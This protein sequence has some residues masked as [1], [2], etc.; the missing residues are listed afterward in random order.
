MNENLK[1]WIIIMVIVVII[2]TLVNL[3][4]RGIEALI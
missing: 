1:Y 4:F 2:S 3:V